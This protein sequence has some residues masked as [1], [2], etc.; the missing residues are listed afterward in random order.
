M[1]SFFS[2]SN[3]QTKWNEMN[4][5]IK[6]KKLQWNMTN[7][8]TRRHTWSKWICI[9]I[10]RFYTNVHI[11]NNRNITFGYESRSNAFELLSAVVPYMICLS[12]CMCICVRSLLFTWMWVQYLIYFN[13][14]IWLP[15]SVWLFI[16][17]ISQRQTPHWNRSKTKQPRMKWEQCLR[18]IWN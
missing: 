12:L 1:I 7:I 18:I 11:T 5:T 3:A 13:P 9:Y 16:L 4:R 6:T 17:E 8:N 2:S 14:I 15:C 10:C